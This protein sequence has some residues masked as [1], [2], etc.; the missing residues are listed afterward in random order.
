MS[1]L[2]FSVIIPV[3][4]GGDYLPLCLDAIA[5]ASQPAIECIVVDDASTDGVAAGADILGPAE[6]GALLHRHPRALGRVQDQVAVVALLL[7]EQL[8]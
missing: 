5:A 7:L 4:N 2:T 1:G 3:H 6:L 8:P